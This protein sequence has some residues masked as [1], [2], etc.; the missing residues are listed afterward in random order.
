MIVFLTLCYCAFLFIMVKIGVIKLTSFWKASPLIWMTLLLI[1]LFIPM[2]WGAPAGPVMLYQNVVA[3]TPNVAGEVIEVPAI[4]REPMKKGDVLFKIDPTVYQA[5][6]D[7]LKANLELSQTRLNQSQRLFAR[8]AGSEY[9]V[10]RF[11]AEVLAYEAQ[12]ASAQWNLDNCTV[13]APGDGYPIAVTLEPGNRVTQVQSAMAYVVTTRNM[14]VGIPQIYMRHIEPGQP[15]EITMKLFPGR[16][17]SGTVQGLALMSPQGQLA[18][19]GQV[20]VAPTGQDPPAPFGVIV[21]PSEETM[22]L[23]DD[24]GRLPG[25]AVGTAAVYTESA[26]FSQVI[27]KVIIRLEMWMNFVNPF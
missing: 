17:F 10:Q 11:R 6:V 20:P 13:V 21:E 16:I 7:Q 3:I 9:D 12:L 22:D 4:G 19:S 18:P 14:V 5:T 2:N 25:G 24:F 1:F 26:Q 27:R 8:G 15:V 23:I